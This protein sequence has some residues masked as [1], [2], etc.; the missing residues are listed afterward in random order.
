MRHFYNL[1]IANKYIFA[2][3]KQL[4]DL[5]RQKNIDADSQFLHRVKKNGFLKLKAAVK[6]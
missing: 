5:K 3:L 6:I 1:K 2:K 4:I